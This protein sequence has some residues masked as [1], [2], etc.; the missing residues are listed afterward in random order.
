MHGGWLP[1]YDLKELLEQNDFDF[2]LLSETW[3]FTGDGSHVISI[4]NYQ[5]SRKDRMVAAYSKG[6]YSIEKVNS[7]FNKNE[8]LEF[9]LL[10][11]KIK[12]KLYAFCLFCK[13]SSLNFYSLTVNFG[14]FTFLYQ[15]V[16][17]FFVWAI[18]I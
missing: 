11:A 6:S 13:S 7:N 10:K 9:L 3:L 15:T 1:T 4:P 12:N 8:Y 5:L 17:D 18:S 2:L 16:D 14:S